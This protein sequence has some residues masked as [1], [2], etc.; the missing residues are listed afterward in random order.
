M[1]YT[2]KSDHAHYAY[3]TSPP[4]YILMKW[5][6]ETGALT[7]F[8]LLHGLEKAPW[9]L[10]SAEPSIVTQ[11]GNYHVVNLRITTK[12]YDEAGEPPNSLKG[13]IMVNAPSPIDG[14]AV[15]AA[16]WEGSGAAWY[17]ADGTLT[18]E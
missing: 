16:I 11:D 7:K 3:P 12:E 5:D 10:S 13:Y 6:S 15:F 17:V 14:A 9:I 18:E 2:F 1:I 8:E 4:E